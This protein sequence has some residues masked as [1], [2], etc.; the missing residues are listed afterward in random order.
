MEHLPPGVSATDRVVLFDGMC[1]LCNAGARL[2]VR[3]DRRRV[4]TLG[5]VQSPEGGA[6]L[7]WHGLPAD[8][9]SSFVLSEGSRLYLRSA[10]VVRIARRLGFPWNLAAALWIV[11]RPIRDWAYDLIARNRYRL[12][13]R[14]DECV[15]LQPGEGVRLLSSEPGRARH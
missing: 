3:I 10:A 6:V 2:L 14:R 12:F 9:Y 1:V 15:V 7:A 13:G 4:F 8:S 11:P 5:T